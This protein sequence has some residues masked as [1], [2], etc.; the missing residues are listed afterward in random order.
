VSENGRASTSIF[1]SD[2]IKLGSLQISTQKITKTS[3]QAIRMQEIRGSGSCAP[4]AWK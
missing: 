4:K 2:L 1:M 3:A